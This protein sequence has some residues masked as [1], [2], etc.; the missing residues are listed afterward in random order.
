MHEWCWESEIPWIW[1]KHATINRIIKFLKVL[2]THLFSVLLRTQIYDFPLKRNIYI[3]FIS[4]F[5]PDCAVCTVCTVWLIPQD[6]RAQSDPCLESVWVRVNSFCVTFPGRPSLPSGTSSP[7]SD[8]ITTASPCGNLKKK[9]STPKTTVF[10]SVPSLDMCV[11]DWDKEAAEKKLL[12]KLWNYKARW[13]N[14]SQNTMLWVHNII[15]STFCCCCWFL[16]V[17]LQVKC[18]E[19]VFVCAL[20]KNKKIDDVMMQTDDWGMIGP[21]LTTLQEWWCLCNVQL[22][23]MFSLETADVV[24]TTASN[25]KALI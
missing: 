10:F 12:G 7:C 1:I 9:K 20:S 14:I 2:G 24:M 5:S 15:I 13:Q 16:T 4:D 21:M 6:K 8:S 18:F 23:M 19:I 17:F 25:M 3:Q 11:H 22:Q